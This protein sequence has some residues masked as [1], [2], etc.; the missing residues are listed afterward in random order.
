MTAPGIGGARPKPPGMV[1]DAPRRN[2]VVLL[3]YLLVLV[4]AV[5]Y[6]VQLF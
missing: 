5:S 1:A 3:V 4:L 6:L 2:A